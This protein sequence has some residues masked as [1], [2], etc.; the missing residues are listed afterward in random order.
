MMG[1]STLQRRLFVDKGPLVAHPADGIEP[2]LGEL[3]ADPLPL[4]ARRHYLDAY[5]ARPANPVYR[6]SAGI[7]HQDAKDW[8]KAFAVFEQWTREEPKAAGAWYQ[9]GRTAVLSGQRLE[10]GVA[11]FNRFL[12]LPEQPGQPE[13]KHAWYRMGQA[14][15]LAGDKAAARK[16]LEKAL[17]I[18]PKLQEARDALA[19]L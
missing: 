12:A 16:A 18:D 8:S 13:H 9:L 10:E 2:P 15:A 4:E 7:I 17:A 11:A 6:M 5:A 19:G 3:L 14:L 1:A